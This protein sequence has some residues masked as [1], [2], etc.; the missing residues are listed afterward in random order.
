MIIVPKCCGKHA[1]QTDP[2]MFKCN[3]CGKTLCAEI[4]I[5]G[6]TKEE[7]HFM[8]EQYLREKSIK[9]KEIRYG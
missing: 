4:V 2:Y 3:I 1:R 8:L 7:E 9:N 5:A 6:R